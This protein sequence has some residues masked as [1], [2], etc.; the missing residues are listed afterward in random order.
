MKEVP[1]KILYQWSWTT[2]LDRKKPGR[3]QEN[4]CRTQG[5][6]LFIENRGRFRIDLE[7]KLRARHVGPDSG[8]E[9]TIN[10]IG[11]SLTDNA[12]NNVP[13]K[14]GDLYNNKKIIVDD[15]ETVMMVTGNLMG[16]YK[17]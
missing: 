9:P 10:E 4:W 15:V 8:Q 1:Y 12:S 2:K 6:L 5:S 17:T 3:N 16:D 11:T 14:L 13:K 7:K